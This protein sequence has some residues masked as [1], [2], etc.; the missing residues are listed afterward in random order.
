MVS[1]TFFSQV[2]HLYILFSALTFHWNLLE[3]VSISMQ[4][5]FHIA[6]QSKKSQMNAV[7]LLHY[8][9]KTIRNTFTNPCGKSLEKSE[10]VN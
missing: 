6:I 3:N 8:N 2:N 1:V 7:I 5:V 9:H 10:T 4:I